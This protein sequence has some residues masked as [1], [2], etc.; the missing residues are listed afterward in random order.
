MY[1]DIPSWLKIRRAYLTP[2]IIRNDLSLAF[3]FLSNRYIYSIGPTI[4]KEEKNK[5]ERSVR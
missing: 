4:D 3:L 2:F 1:I 5:S